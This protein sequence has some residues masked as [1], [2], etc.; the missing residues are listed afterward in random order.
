[1]TWNVHLFADIEYQERLLGYEAAKRGI[2]SKGNV[3]TCWFHREIELPFFPT[4][5]LHLDLKLGVK[6]GEHLIASVVS[7]NWECEASW[8][9][10]HVKVFG[11]CDFRTKGSLD[12]AAE[13]YEKRKWRRVGPELPRTFDE[14]LKLDLS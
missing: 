9:W 11:N 3:E 14:L 2:G 7:V 5:D 4:K 10:C 13:W 1:M 6:E 8:L 12:E